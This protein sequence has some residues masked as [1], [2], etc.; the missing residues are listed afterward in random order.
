MDLR[1]GHETRESRCAAYVETLA[2]P[3]GYADRKAPLQALY[4]ADPAG[5]A[6]ERGADDRP[7]QVHCDMAFGHTLGGNVFFFGFLW[8]RGGREQW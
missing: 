8:R 3:L 4:G 7:G 1:N 5:R 2:P 6:Q